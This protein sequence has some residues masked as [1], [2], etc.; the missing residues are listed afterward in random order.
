MGVVAA[1][2]GFATA[3]G[4]RGP[5]AAKGETEGRA[6]RR[7]TSVGEPGGPGWGGRAPVT[8]GGGVGLTG[9]GA[10]SCCTCYLGGAT[11]PLSNTS[12][13]YAAPRVDQSGLGDAW[14]QSLSPFAVLAEQIDGATKAVS[15]PWDRRVA[16]VPAVAGVA[17]EG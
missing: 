1:A 16:L 6:P 11:R 15:W 9:I 13:A 3:T 12:V 7:E 17:V 10:G 14:W 8:I 5:L 4:E 2:M